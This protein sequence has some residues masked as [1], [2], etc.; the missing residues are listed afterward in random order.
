MISALPPL[1]FA[2]VAPRTSMSLEKLPCDQGAAKERGTP[3]RKPITTP[4]IKAASDASRPIHVAL[5]PFL[6]KCCETSCQNERTNQC[7]YNQDGPD[8]YCVDSRG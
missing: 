2:I 3:K 1:L 7:E 5:K 4:I 8:R 6:G